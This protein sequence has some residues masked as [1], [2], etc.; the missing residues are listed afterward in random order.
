MM[1]RPGEKKFDRYARI[2]RCRWWSYS[3]LI[4][5]CAHAHFPIGLRQWGADQILYR[6]ICLEYGVVAI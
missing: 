2:C 6:V 4:K 5:M 1:R 3:Y